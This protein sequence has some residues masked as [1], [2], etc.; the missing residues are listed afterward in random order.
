MSDSFTVFSATRRTNGAAQCEHRGGAAVTTE[1]LRDRLE[2]L[3][4]EPMVD[5]TLD[6]QAEQP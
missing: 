6:E 3:A 4:G 1:W 5:V 2:A